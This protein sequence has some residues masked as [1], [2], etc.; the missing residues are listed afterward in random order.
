[1]LLPKK[2]KYR[3]AQ[4]GGKKIKG[5]ANSGCELAFGTYGLQ[6]VGKGR[7]S[8]RQ[9]EAGRRCITRSMKRAGKMWIRV[10]PAIPV[11]KK[12]A[13]VRMGS[14]KGSVDHWACRIRPGLIIYEVDGI[15]EK[16]AIEALQKASAKLPFQTKIIK[17]V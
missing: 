17:F 6:S 2:T 7:L 8:S 11:S 10:F 16:N 12:P 3:K 4:K 14:G 9:I 5:T 1:M 15:S 13:E